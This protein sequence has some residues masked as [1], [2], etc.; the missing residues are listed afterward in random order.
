ME[1]EGELSKQ[2]EMLLVVGATL[3]K[4][5]RNSKSLQKVAFDIGLLEVLVSILQEVTEENYEVE[6]QSTVLA[7]VF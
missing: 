1:V 2:Q 4:L 3:K 7:T 6:K 5:L